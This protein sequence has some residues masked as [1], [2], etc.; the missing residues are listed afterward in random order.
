MNP[1]D[2]AGPAAGDQIMWCL[3]VG[4][5]SP[6]TRSE[7]EP[8]ALSIPE[9]WFLRTVP[10]RRCCIHCFPDWREFMAKL[11][12]RV[13]LCAGLVLCGASIRA[14][15]DLAVPDGPTVKTTKTEKGRESKIHV[16][17]P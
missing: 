12:V 1:P 8:G 9:L 6:R 16:Y 17:L 3:F 15:G 13:A 11:F 2:R 5:P 10:C 14:E 7:P 4:D